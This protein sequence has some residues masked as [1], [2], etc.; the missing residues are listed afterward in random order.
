[1]GFFDVH[2]FLRTKLWIFLRI[3]PTWHPS[4]PQKNKTVQSKT[5]NYVFWREP[6][7]QPDRPYLKNMSLQ[8][9][10]STLI[11]KNRSII[12]ADKHIKS[13][14]VSSFSV[15]SL[16]QCCIFWINN[17]PNKFL[18]QDFVRQMFPPKSKCLVLI[19]Q[20]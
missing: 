11:S 6:K 15:P 20:S 7:L 18:N 8:E 1:M 12:D 14:I 5:R 17:G 19:K 2:L 4:I 16:R 13:T 3:C 9:K 10:M